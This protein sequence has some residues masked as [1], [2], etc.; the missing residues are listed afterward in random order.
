[1]FST[2]VAALFSCIVLFGAAGCSAS[3]RPEARSGS[4]ADVCASTDASPALAAAGSA[5]LRADRIYAIEPLY[6]KR[7]AGKLTYE[8]LGGATV[9]IK[10]DG[11]I[12]AD[13]LQRS[14]DCQVAR[15]TWVAKSISVEAFPREYVVRIEGESRESAHEIYE[16]AKAL[17][18]EAVVEVD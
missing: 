7:P 8:R 1:M 5:A 2:R 18:P 15:G 4:V 17:A 9:R 13:A 11:S 12:S 6:V 14:F 16:K 3:T 10:N